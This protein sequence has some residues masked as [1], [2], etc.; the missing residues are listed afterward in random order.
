MLLTCV[1]DLFEYAQKG[2]VELLKILLDYFYLYRIL[3]DR[4]LNILTWTSGINFNIIE[5]KLLNPLKVIILSEYHPARFQGIFQFFE[6]FIVN[7]VSFA[8]NKKV[9]SSPSYIISFRILGNMPYL[10]T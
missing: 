9:R 10:S 6:N 1:N 2:E 3:D 4:V 7:Y 8:N 5:K